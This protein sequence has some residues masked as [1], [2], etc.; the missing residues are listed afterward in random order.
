MHPL[1]RALRFLLLLFLAVLLVAALTAGHQPGTALGQPAG[2]A[3]EGSSTPLPATPTRTPIPEEEIGST[4]GLVVLALLMVFVILAAVL[5]SQA[6]R[7][8]PPGG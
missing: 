1:T 8:T 3:D 6:G 7:R 2:Q 5:V 4:D